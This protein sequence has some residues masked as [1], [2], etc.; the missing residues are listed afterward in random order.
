VRV[1]P[2]ITAT[3]VNGSNGHHPNGRPVRE[4][5][6]GR[7]AAGIIDLGDGSGFLN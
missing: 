1:A 2:T 5:D 7:S 3:P 6:N 4:G